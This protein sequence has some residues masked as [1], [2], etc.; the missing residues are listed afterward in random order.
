MGQQ[1]GQDLGRPKEDRH[2]AATCWW[3]FPFALIYPPNVEGLKAMLF[4]W[5]F[6]C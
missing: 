3:T 2:P 6:I 4:F 5:L 1:T